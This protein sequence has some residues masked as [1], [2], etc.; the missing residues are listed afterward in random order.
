MEPCDQLK[1]RIGRLEVETQ[2]PRLGCRR[3]SADKRMKPVCILI[4]AL[5]GSSVGC[6]GSRRDDTVPPPYPDFESAIEA[7]ATSSDL[8]EANAAAVQLYSGGVPAIDVLREHLSDDRIIPSPFCSRAVNAGSISVGEQSFWTIQDMIETTRLPKSLR[9]Y[10]ILTSDSVETW[11]DDRKGKSIRELQVDAATASFAAAK[12][13]F[14]SRGN[15]NA[16]AAMELYGEQLQTLN[17][18]ARQRDR[19]AMNPSGG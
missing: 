8:S 6:S 7:I 2:L 4:I 9:N 19:T 11:L 5:V 16:R 18:D 17:S 13:D 1:S 3:R 12:K 10:L 15:S 14:Q